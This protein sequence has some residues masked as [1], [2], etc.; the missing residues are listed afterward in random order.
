M[1]KKVWHGVQGKVT[2]ATARITRGRVQYAVKFAYEVQDRSY[3]GSFYTF[4]AYEAGDPVV[5]RYDPDRPEWNN[6][7][8]QGRGRRVV[9]FG[10]VC[11]LLLLLLALA[12]VYLRLKGR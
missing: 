6:F 3:T 11:F 2:E 9:T 12:G 4:A 10:V 7:A 1:T 8:A 5:V